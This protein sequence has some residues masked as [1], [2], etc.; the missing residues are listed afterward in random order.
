M[1]KRLLASINHPVQH[2]CVSPTAVEESFD[3]CPRLHYPGLVKRDNFYHLAE[4]YHRNP[5]TEVVRQSFLS[6][7]ERHF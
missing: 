1:V 6:T 2:G 5:K 3:L 4:M 7:A